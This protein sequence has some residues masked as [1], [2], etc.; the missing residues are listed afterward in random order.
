[1]FTLKSSFL[2]RISKSF[3]LPLLLLLTQSCSN[4]P[5]GQELSESF[6][7]PVEKEPAKDS[8]SRIVKP[9]SSAPLKQK[10]DRASS[11]SASFNEEVISK[12]NSSLK[13]VRKQVRR[14]KKNPIFTP[15][16]YRI[17]IKLSATNPS[18]PAETVTKAL[19]T[20]GVI[21][22]VEMIERIEDSLPKA[23]RPL[24]KKR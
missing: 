4:K 5:I 16:P 21:F 6:D 15:Q 12:S 22:E 14:Q 19:R 8:N 24:R 20:A 10:D 3:F 11:E 18:A 7:F 23:A 9:Y 13:L 17:T 1:M 2:V